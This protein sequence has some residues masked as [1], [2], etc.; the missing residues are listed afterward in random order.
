MSKLVERKTMQRSGDR[1]R[2]VD[3]C[4]RE[5]GD[6]GERVLC[7]WIFILGG[8]KLCSKGL[9]WT[10]EEERNFRFLGPRG[11]EFF[12]SVES[13]MQCFFAAD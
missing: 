7:R 9:S 4:E 3:P 10:L 12:A 2:H 6:G 1:V 8:G 11:L 13:V 5:R